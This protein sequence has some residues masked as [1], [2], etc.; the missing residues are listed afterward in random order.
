MKRREATAVSFGHRFVF[1]L[2]KFNFLSAECLDMGSISA[3]L[4]SKVYVPVPNLD[5]E[6]QALT[7]TVQLV[8]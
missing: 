4:L 2:L 7:P 6:W 3:A 1:K 8:P 5:S